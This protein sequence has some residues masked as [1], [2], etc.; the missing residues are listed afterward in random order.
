MASFCGKDKRRAPDWIDPLGPNQSGR[1]GPTGA[2]EMRT[3]VFKNMNASSL[4]QAREATQEAAGAIRSAASDPV[5]QTSKNALSKT[6]SGGYLQ[7][8]PY[9]TDALKKS[10]EASDARMTGAREEARAGLEGQ[11]AAT[12]SNFARNGVSFGTGQTQ[13]QEGA[14]TALEAQVARGEQAGAAEMAASEADTLAQNYGRERGLQVGAATAAPQVASGQAQLLS[15]LPSMYMQPDT[16]AAKV[17][18]GLST[19]QG[20]NP[21]IS[22]DPGVIDYATQILS[23]TGGSW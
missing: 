13:A 16:D 8:N 11:Q 10:R 9:L 20:L 17:I 19:G 23:S 14:K 4:P 18:S 1:M 3:G 15:A 2:P 21:T 5:W 22:R 7:A 12:R 6:A